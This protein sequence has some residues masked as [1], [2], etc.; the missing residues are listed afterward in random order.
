[1]K[2]KPITAAEAGSRG[3]KA[4]MKKMTAQQRLAISRKGGLATQE[5]IRRLRGLSAKQD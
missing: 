1:M 3:G 2:K 4:R 5:K